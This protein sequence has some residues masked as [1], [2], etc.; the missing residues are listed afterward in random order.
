MGATSVHSRRVPEDAPGIQAP[1]LPTVVSGIYKGG[2]L[3]TAVAVALAERLAF[4]GLRMLLLTSDSQHDARHRLGVKPSAPRVAR[5]KR[6]GGTVTVRGLRPGK[7]VD[8][9]YGGAPELDSFDGAVVD[10]AP[11]AEAGAL[12]GVLLVSPMD[13]MDAVRNAVTMLRR[14]PPNTDVVLVKYHRQPH[15][16]WKRTV[17]DIEEAANISD[18][19]YLIDPIPQ[20]KPIR[21]AHDEG[22][23]VWTLPRRGN[24]KAFLDAVETLATLFWEKTF[25][26]QQ[27]PD[28]PRRQ[29]A[30]VHVPGWSDDET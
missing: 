27:L 11:V 8:L 17:D 21:Q 9:L 29:A 16:E 6:G 20:S 24:T 14:T 2:C 12:P 30:F 1:R 25:P 5:V 4:A 7:I 26:G 19:R 18:L 10:T 22:R 3:K 15:A 23:S 13:S 28:L